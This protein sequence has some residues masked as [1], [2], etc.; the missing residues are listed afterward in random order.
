MDVTN[1]KRWNRTCAAAIA[2][3]FLHTQS[4]SG[5]GGSGRLY[6]WFIPRVTEQGLLLEQDAGL[7]DQLAAISPKILLNLFG[8]SVQPRWC[9]RYL[10]ERGQRGEDRR[11]GKARDQGKRVS[12]ERAKVPDV[13]FTSRRPPLA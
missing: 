8:Y 10:G 4:G 6:G 5:K 9:I 12:V 2:T 13:G 3:W 1:Q 11:H 7:L